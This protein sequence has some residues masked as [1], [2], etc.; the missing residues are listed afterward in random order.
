MSW[1]PW[2]CSP[3]EKTGQ[4][5]GVKRGAFILAVGNDD[6]DILFLLLSSPYTRKSTSWNCSI[7]K[8][9]RVIKDS[10]VVLP[11]VLADASQINPPDIND[12][13]HFQTVSYDL[14]EATHSIQF[15]PSLFKSALEGKR[16]IDHI[17]WGPWGFGD[18]AETIVTFSSNGTFYHCLFEAQFQVSENIVFAEMVELDFKRCI[19]QGSDDIPLGSWSAMWHNQVSVNDVAPY[20]Q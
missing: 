15:H 17:T 6:G 8:V 14:R 5:L 13:P 1:A 12:F 11:D 4:S 9:I 20:L 7:I 10:L 19:S 3:G 16:F 18:V 2:T